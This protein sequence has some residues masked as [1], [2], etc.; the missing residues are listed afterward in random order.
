MQ[1]KMLMQHLARFLFSYCQSP[2]CASLVNAQQLWAEKV[3]SRQFGYEA[4]QLG[5]AFSLQSAWQSCP[6]RR[7]LLLTDTLLANTQ[8]IGH[9]AQLPIKSDT[10]D[11]VLLHY[12]LEQSEE[13]YALLREVDRVLICDGRVIIM[14][15]QPANAWRGQL[16]GRHHRA[17]A[18][19]TPLGPGRVVDS[20]QTLGYEIQCVDFFPNKGWKLWFPWLATPFSQGY[21]LIAQKKT[22]R[23]K[24]IRLRDGWRWQSLLPQ[25]AR[26]NMAT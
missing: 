24:L 26:R 16:W 25:L 7:K 4:L 15:F 18:Y 3:L 2:W 19:L 9:Y 1:W 12:V 22:S 8:V 11:V 13:P 6:I 20:L 17:C 21:A 10:V 23:V 5:Q 14:G